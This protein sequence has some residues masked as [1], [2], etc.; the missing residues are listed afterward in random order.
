M[1]N[2]RAWDEIK[3]HDLNTAVEDYP[4]YVPDKLRELDEIR[5]QTIPQKVE[6]R[7]STDQPYL[8]KSELLTLVEWKL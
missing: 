3:Y 6:R 2:S 5:L 8:E 4:N 1:Q 7:K